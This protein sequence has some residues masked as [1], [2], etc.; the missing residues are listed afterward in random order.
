MGFGK[1][2]APAVRKP[3][4]KHHHQH[5][6]FKVALALAAAAALIMSIIALTLSATTSSTPRTGSNS[7]SGFI[8]AQC[9]VNT[10]VIDR[11]EGSQL[12]FTRYC[13]NS[14]SIYTCGPC[15]SDASIECWNYV[16]MLASEADSVLADTCDDSPAVSTSMPCTQF[17]QGWLLVC[18]SASTASTV[19]K[20]YLC[21]G[22]AWTFFTNFQGATGAT[23]ASGSTGATGATGATG[24]S[25]STGATG[26][27][28]SSGS[29]GASGA[30]GSSGASG[31]TG[32]T[33]ATGA[34][35][36]TGA[37]GTPPA[38]PRIN[39]YM[40]QGN[41]VSIDI[42]LS[43]GDPDV[44]YQAVSVQR[45]LVTTYSAQTPPMS[46]PAFT[47]YLTTV[48]ITGPFTLQDGDIIRHQFF[49]GP[50]V[51]LATLLGS[52]VVTFR[53]TCLQRIGFEPQLV[54]WNGSD[55]CTYPLQ[56]GS[57]SG[58]VAQNISDVQAYITSQPGMSNRFIDMNTGCWIDLEPTPGGK[59]KRGAP[60]IPTTIRTGEP[61]K[62]MIFDINT[63]SNV[64][65]ELFFTSSEAPFASGTYNLQIDWGDASPLV[66]VSGTHVG[67][68]AV[69]VL[70]TY[71][72]P[73][74]RR[75]RL[76]GRATHFAR[77]GQTN[78]MTQ[79]VQFGHLETTVMSLS[80]DTTTGS[81]LSVLDPIGPPPTIQ[82]L[83][84]FSPRAGGG[85][86]RYFN[87]TLWN[88]PALTDIQNAFTRNEF[89]GFRAPG[90]LNFQSC[91][92]SGIIHG[93]LPKTLAFGSGRTFFVAFQFSVLDS[94]NDIASWDLSASGT[95]MLGTFVS[96]AFTN[97]PL[98]LTNV[99][100]SGVTNVVSLFANAVFSQG[101]AGLGPMN[102]VTNGGSMF[103]N[104][105][106][107]SFVTNWLANF[108]TPLMTQATSMF[109]QASMGPHGAVFANLGPLVQANFMF[110]SAN[111]GTGCDLTGLQT[112]AVTTADQF[113]QFS[114]CQSA[115]TIR[116][117]LL[118]NNTLSMS[119]AFS[120]I[121][122]LGG[123][124]GL[125]TPLLQS[126]SQLFEATSFVE[127]LG[128]ETWHFPSVVNGFGMFRLTNFNLHPLY[129][130]SFGFT[131]ALQ[132]TAAM[133]SVTAN[134]P[135]SGHVLNCSTWN[136]A[137]VVNMNSMFSDIGRGV[138]PG[139]PISIDTTGWNTQKVTNMA[140]LF[141]DS[142]GSNRITHIYG[143]GGW[144]TPMLQN[145]DQLFWSRGA[146]MTGIDVTNWDMSKVTTAFLFASGVQPATAAQLNFTLWN[147]PL[148]TVLTRAYRG[149]TAIPGMFSFN[150]AQVINM[151]QMLEGSSASPNL[152]TMSLTSVISCSN[153]IAGALMLQ[154]Q[155]DG[156]L[157]KWATGSTL[158]GQSMGGP[159][160]NAFDGFYPVTFTPTPVL[161]F[162]SA[163]A[164]TDRNTLISRGWTLLDGGVN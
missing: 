156:I 6:V 105:I 88:L 103:S 12:G 124:S 147:T 13:N 128:S 85:V 3:I 65:V 151:D 90:L 163:S 104:T 107:T 94:W 20:M 32:A 58:P 44:H 111:L 127:P 95:N 102:A 34:T 148:L 71:G 154:T 97:S 48:T 122:T 143:M 8:V 21:Q 96:V 19:N 150:T 15:P 109:S 141:M 64:R 130:D 159:R 23:G 139:G 134:W 81:T 160:S 101:I 45:G 110:Y 83:R 89:E 54:C 56:L 87:S 26:A 161:Q 80:N 112:T 11:C 5:Y 93:A 33:G 114:V 68:G 4:S 131:S 25:G 36:S 40:L 133:F 43:V 38:L 47:Q 66:D 136:M 69:D 135:V 117:P 92:Q 99:N 24:T 35:G 62:Y 73:G 120:Y 46:L 9:S 70:R 61:A 55:Y 63:D 162:Y 59:R 113:M 17:I 121:N 74:V 18:G 31:S 78:R 152:S 158:A 50:D 106:H 157:N 116:A 60:P 41:G 118:W 123:L 53:Q 115:G 52:Y 42:D 91:C 132:N 75:V 22:T 28:G 153:F 125:Y 164:T 37:K 1:T 108:S 51:G 77:L 129:G 10:T 100:F 142:S 84:N 67:G 29:S 138:L 14:M 86:R 82:S 155:Y 76:A 2:R 149:T 119:L 30:T 137:N 39:F 57:I 146:L 145:V 140:G 79:L 27:T 49:N 7:G 16:T 72:S 126:A 98:V 144:Q